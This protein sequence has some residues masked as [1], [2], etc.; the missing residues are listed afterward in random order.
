MPFCDAFANKTK[1]NRE[2]VRQVKKYALVKRF[3]LARGEHVLDTV[4]Q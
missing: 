3:V 2:A 1:E 4:A